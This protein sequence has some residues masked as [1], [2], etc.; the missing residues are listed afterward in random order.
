MHLHTRHITSLATAL[1]LVCSLSI[2]ACA[3]RETTTA[4]DY[5]A[6]QSAEQTEEA[7]QQVEEQAS[8][9]TT[10]ETEATETPE[11]NTEEQADDKD[12]EKKP[13]LNTQV[14]MSSISISDKIANG[15]VE[16]D[17]DALNAIPDYEGDEYEAID[18][19]EPS[20]IDDIAASK[21]NA[22]GVLWY[23]SGF[24][25]VAPDHWKATVGSDEIGFDGTKYELAAFM[26]TWDK[27]SCNVTAFDA[28]DCYIANLSN[29]GFYNIQYLDRGTITIN[30]AAHGSYAQALADFDWKGETSKYV[31]DVNFFEGKN[32]L[33]GLAFMTPAS[34]YSTARPDID[35]VW[36]SV[37]YVSGEEL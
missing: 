31:I 13:L 30:G 24:A 34:T 21:A 6:G 26:V 35:A 17:E 32:K 37:C 19:S 29:G 10:T 28:T 1:A 2:A 16:V 23:T 3:Q 8:D 7:A 20:V 36:N 25:I 18:V 5:A 14:L 9:E 15:E 33:N 11:T 27:A 4:E 12:T 22:N